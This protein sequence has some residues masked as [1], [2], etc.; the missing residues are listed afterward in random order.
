MIP[1]HGLKYPKCVLT[2][3][4]VVSTHLLGIW[5]HLGAVKQRYL[6]KKPICEKPGFWKKII[7]T[8]RV[9]G[10]IFRMVWQFSTYRDMH[11]VCGKLPKHNFL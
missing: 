5:G 3:K 7:L 2:Q 10:A 9:L 6:V 1:N 11:M 4:G 8:H